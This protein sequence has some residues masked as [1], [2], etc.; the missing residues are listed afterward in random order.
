MDLSVMTSLL[1]RKIIMNAPISCGIKVCCLAA[2]VGPFS[3]PILDDSESVCHHIAPSDSLLVLNVGEER[4][5]EDA[6]C[7]WP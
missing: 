3:M 4:E 7:I 2:A 1:G 6:R 5:L